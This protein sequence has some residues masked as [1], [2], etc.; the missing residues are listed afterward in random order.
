[1]MGMPVA[2]AQARIS[3][4]EFGE[5]MAYAEVEPFGPGR[6]DARAGVIASL[7]A[8]ANRDTDRRAEPY[9]PEDFFPNLGNGRPSAPA[10][11]TPEEQL[12][13]MRM[14]TES[15]SRVTP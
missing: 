6:D 15:M 3:S 5:W 11:Q 8:N 2:E 9:E 4:A 10:D 13:I 1:M 7:I 12:A 14:I